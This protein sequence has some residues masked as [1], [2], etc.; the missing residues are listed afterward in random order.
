MCRFTE[1]PQ[2][3]GEGQVGSG[4]M[5]HTVNT[6]TIDEPWEIPMTCPTC[7]GGGYIEGESYLIDM[8]DLDVMAGEAE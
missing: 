3:N 1:C 7:G 6:A 5:S 2:C 4:R 8:E